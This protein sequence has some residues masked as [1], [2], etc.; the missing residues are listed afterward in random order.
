[1]PHVSTVFDWLARGSIGAEVGLS[2]GGGNVVSFAGGPDF[3]GGSGYLQTIA[4]RIMSGYIG[5]S[6]DAVLSAMRGGQDRHRVLRAR[7]RSVLYGRIVQ[8]PQADILHP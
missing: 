2:H 4:R 6:H 8:L 3:E 7:C 1:M 5:F